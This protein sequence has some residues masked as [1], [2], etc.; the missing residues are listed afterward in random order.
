MAAPFPTLKLGDTG[1]LNTT[2]LTFTP[3]G[4]FFTPMAVR[5]S[6]CQLG[7]AAYDAMLASVG[8]KPV[9]LACYVVKSL[10]CNLRGAI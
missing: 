1:V 6:C 8:R 10:L 7:H 9:V 4:R 5:P 2:A 3:G